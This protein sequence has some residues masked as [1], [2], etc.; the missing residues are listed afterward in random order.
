MQTCLDSKGGP[1]PFI[2]KIAHM[3]EIEKI[4]VPEVFFYHKNLKISKP[5]NFDSLSCS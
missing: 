2:T 5:Y 4:N 3:C 1:A